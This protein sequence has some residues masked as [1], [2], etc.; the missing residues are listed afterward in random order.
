MKE[1]LLLTKKP[2]LKGDDGHKTFSIRIRTSTAE[3]LERLAIKT[4]RSRNDVICTLLDWAL[5]N[6]ETK[7]DQHR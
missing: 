3:E 6:T 2:V 7:E 5:A 1:K 4:D